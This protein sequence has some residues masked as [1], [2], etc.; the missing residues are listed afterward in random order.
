[1]SV[2]CSQCGRFPF[3]EMIESPSKE[4]ECS[5]YCKR[6]VVKSE[7]EKEFYERCKQSARESNI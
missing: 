3:C 5:K 2:R 4:F 6:K 7:N 1:M